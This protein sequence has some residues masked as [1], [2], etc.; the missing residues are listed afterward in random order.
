MQLFQG[1]NV[2]TVDVGGRPLTL[3]AGLLAPQAGGA[4][5]VRYG[6][7]VLLATAVMSREVRQ[8]TNF[9]PLTVEFEERLYA[10]GRIPGS[11]FRREG[12]PS[13]QAILV[14][15][16]VDRPLRP[17]FP[18]GMRNEM[19]MIVTA[20]A[21]DGENL[22]DPLA[23]IAASAALAISDIPWNGP[24]AATT[25]GFVDGEFV[26]NPTAD[27]MTNSSLNLVAAGT[28]RQHPDGR[29]GRPRVAR[30]PDA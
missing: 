7:T 28:E 21:T 14:S 11:F 16:L 24:I 10:A 18:K 26:V 22:M 19:Q 23:I 13:E 20:L 5:T 15:R 3:E 1:T 9:F 8:G 30:R 2:Y 4:V 27:Q 17:L 6:D 12:R 29:S 25:I